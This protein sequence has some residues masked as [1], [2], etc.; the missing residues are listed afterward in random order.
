MKR[1]PAILLCLLAVGPVR[2]EPLEER[3]TKLER[4]LNSST[5]LELLGKVEQMQRDMRLL[6]GELEEVRHLGEQAKRRQRDLYL[7]ID[8]RL[9]ALETTAAGTAP[10]LPLAPSAAV[11]PAV[12][13]APADTPPAAEPPVAAV[14]TTAA[15]G[16]DPAQEQRE[17]Q[18]AFDLLKEA[19]FE[20]AEPAFQEFLRKYPD[21][22]YA[23]NAQ[24]WLGETYYVTRQ[25]EPALK[26]FQRVLTR[27]PDS[28]KISHA[29]LK[30][31]YI[32]H[33]LGDIEAAT[34]T[35]TEVQDRFPK[36]SAS[37]LARERL[38][39][40]KRETQ[41]GSAATP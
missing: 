40:I 16:T 5:L 26:E 36:E 21:G 41:P 35:L 23:G 33:E 28:P 27:Y 4:M 37:R 11:A 13:P 32:Q 3:V 17:Y 8:K 7:D 39:R 25:Y 2:A 14:G 38:A 30:V 9:Q 31:G 19:R 10:V 6:R 29:M 18:Q 1:L 34:A 12:E 20:K 22:A 15:A 24:Y